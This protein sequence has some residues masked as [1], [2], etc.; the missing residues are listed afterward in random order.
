VFGVATGSIDALARHAYG[1]EAGWSTARARP[2]WQVAYAYDRWRPTFF[3][4]TAD[5]TDPWRGGIRR[6]VETNAGMLLNSRRVRWT[7][8]VLAEIHGSNERFDCASGAPSCAEYAGLDINRA[9]LISGIAIQAARMFG[10]S[11]SPEEGG[12]LAATLELSRSA[13]RDRASS[14]AAAID[15]RQYFR[16][17]PRH[18]VVAVRGA[19]AASWGDEPLRRVFSAAGSDPQS[20]GF[21]FG[22]DAVGLIR[23]VPEDELLG[24]RAAVMNVDYRFPLARPERGLGT[25]PVLLR[26]VHGAFFVDAGHAWSERFRSEDVQYSVGGELSF[27]AVLAYFAPL[28]FSAGAAW[29]SGGLPSSDRGFAAFARVG[30][31]F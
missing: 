11:I 18:A 24:F 2:D 21:R 20:G 22:S 8:S 13:F 1:V 14:Q 31:A 23:G 28:T 6:T 26:S 29:R 3:V 12:R 10:Y 16:V 9:S 5:D 30:R 4:A 27:D 15:G 25:V 17:W 7:Q 19:A